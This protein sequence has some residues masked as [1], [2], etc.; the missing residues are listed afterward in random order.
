MY[1]KKDINNRKIK[2]KN[3]FLP[4]GY[5][6]QKLINNYNIGILTVMCEKKIFKNI[7]FQ[8]KI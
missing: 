7:S 3:S 8:K 6:T 2:I 4:S 5:I 1:L